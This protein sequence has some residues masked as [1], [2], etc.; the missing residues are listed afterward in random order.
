[1]EALARGGAIPDEQWNKLQS[2]LDDGIRQV[3]RRTPPEDYQPAIEQYQDAIR[4][5]AP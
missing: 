4:Q 3:N 1:M 2:N 5:I